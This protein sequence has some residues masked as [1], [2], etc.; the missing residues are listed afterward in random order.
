MWKEEDL[1]VVFMILVLIIDATV[2]DYILDIHNY[3]MKKNNM[4]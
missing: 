2:A 4:I 3:L 1:V